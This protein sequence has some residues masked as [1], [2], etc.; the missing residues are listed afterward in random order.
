MKYILLVI[1]VSIYNLALA[2]E[3][4][5]TRLI[6]KVILNEELSQPDGLVIGNKKIIILDYLQSSLIIYNTLNDSLNSVSSLGRGP[7]EFTNP[8]LLSISNDIVSFIDSNNRLLTYNL[9]QHE[10]TE[11]VYKGDIGE[12]ELLNEE[13]IL[14][15][16]PISMLNNALN[17]KDSLIKVI[18][19]EGNIIERFASYK[20]YFSGIPA[21]FSEPYISVDD[22]N[23][24]MS[25][26]YYPELYVFDK[27]FQAKFKFDLT[28]L[29][30]LTAES[31][32]YKFN[33]N[34]RSVGVKKIIAGIHVIDSRIFIAHNSL[35]RII[36]DEYS[37]TDS[38]LRLVNTFSS[39]NEGEINREDDN[40][41]A[42]I[43]FTF[44]Y[45]RKCIN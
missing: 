18:D 19:F 30:N 38:E 31:T 13:Y 44:I 41:L 9:K 5:E 7:G 27:D 21:G 40:Y 17:E 10:F 28:K 23:I 12:V 16:N 29:S 45:R 1:I 26:V 14:I 4:K 42:L 3:S 36:I 15:F 32:N 33:Q 37:L 20:T 2:Q 34:K 11:V 6:R 25:F 35:E 43:D 24:Y 8:R 22:E 39:I